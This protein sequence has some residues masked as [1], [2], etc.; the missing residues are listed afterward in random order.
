MNQAISK[1]QKI[2]EKLKH[3]SRHGCYFNPP[4]KDKS[5]MLITSEES[6]FW[7]SSF[8]NRQLISAKCAGTHSSALKSCTPCG[9][10]RT[11]AHLFRAFT[12]ASLHSTPSSACCVAPIWLCFLVVVLGPQGGRQ[13]GSG[14]GCTCC[15]RWAC[16]CT[17]PRH[18]TPPRS[19][20]RSSPAGRLAAS[21][22]PT[23]P[24][25]TSSCSATR[26]PGREPRE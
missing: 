17:A 10:M 9:R 25:P 18:W 1:F 6:G 22:V 20:P 23:A 4:F 12:A 3:L 7:N 8:I 15:S 21:A 14:Q 5:E 13:G 26:G 16:D 24:P 11:Q 19:S 2:T